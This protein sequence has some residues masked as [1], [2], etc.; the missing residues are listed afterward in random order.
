MGGQGIDLGEPQA[1]W[2]AGAGGGGGGR[3]AI[4][5]RKKKTEKRWWSP[6]LVEV[7]GKCHTRFIYLLLIIYFSCFHA[8]ISAEMDVL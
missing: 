5:W 4:S 2:A 7:L 1:L 6:S 3:G 8:S